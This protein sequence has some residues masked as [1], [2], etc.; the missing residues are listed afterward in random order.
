ML[1][2]LPK[3]FTVVLN[4]EHAEDTLRCVASLRES[5][6][7][8]QHIIVIDNGSPEADLLALKE[9]LPSTTV[10]ETGKNLGFGA[11]NN[12]GISYALDR[13]PDFV[14]VLNPDTVV[15]P[16]TLRR[17]VETMM[18]HPDIGIAG[19]KIISGKTKEP[20]IWFIGGAIDWR[21][22]GKP[23]H[24]FMRRR[25]SDVGIRHLI[26][27]DYVTGASMLIRREV[28]DS[29]G[30]LPE[31]YFLYFEE[32]DFNVRAQRAGW[33]CAVDP[34]SRLTHYQRSRDTLP[35]AAYVY[36]Y[37][38]NRFIFGKRFSSA[39]E[40]VILGDI[41]GFTGRW[42]QQVVEHESSWLPSFEELVGWAMQDARAGRTGPRPGVEERDHS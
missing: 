29:I 15:E 31:E 37:T 39:T 23:S 18:L 22:G 34:R 35:S 36:Y 13:G 12:V 26:P 8:N 16:E 25:E 9:G 32:T 33:L 5:S 21:L 40:S 24:S 11:G 19:S 17:V 41:E 14:W 7:R 10:I 27:V 28:F 3:V 6:Y 38:R 30:L 1:S 20:T 4:Y 2:T 42:R